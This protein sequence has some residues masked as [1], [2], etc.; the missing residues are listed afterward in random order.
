MAAHSSNNVVHTLFDIGILAKGVDGVLEIAGGILLL[1]L[2]P[3]RIG[4]ILRLLTQHELGEDPHDPVAILLQHTAQHLS[5]GT[6]LFAAFFL[7]WHGLVKVGLVTAL[8]RRQWW[9]YPLAIAAFGLFLAYQL[10]RY[11]HTHSVWLLA[12]SLLDGFVIVITWL[13][14]RRVRSLPKA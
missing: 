10:Y 3:D 7:L 12:L 6:E 5:A 8:L 1:F 13:E 11:L 14:Y 9:A 4:S 2:T